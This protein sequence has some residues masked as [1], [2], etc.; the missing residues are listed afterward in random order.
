[1]KQ[2]FLWLIILIVLL[3]VGLLTWFG[4]RFAATEKVV[5][6]QRF[7]Q[8]MQERLSDVN[9]QVAAQFDEAERSLQQVTAFD[10]FRLDEI[11]EVVRTKPQVSQIFVLRSDGEL[12]YPQPGSTL[13]VT[14]RSFLQQASKMFTGKDLQNA[15]VLREAE[16]LRGQQGTSVTPGWNGNTPVYPVPPDPSLQNFYNVAPTTPPTANL[17]PAFPQASPTEPGPFPFPQ[18]AMTPPLQS[19]DPL[20]GQSP[21]TRRMQQPTMPPQSR[22]V[23]LPGRTLGGESGAGGVAEGQQQA[24]GGIPQFPG[25]QEFTAPPA[26]DDNRAPTANAMPGAMPNANAQQ[27]IAW[28]QSSGWFVWYWDRGMNLIYWQRRPSGLIVG[29]AL[30]RSRWISDLIC[31]ARDRPVSQNH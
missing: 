25:F 31:A 7:Q 30:E 5:T 6:Q 27:Q 15:V 19:A 12:L 11:R 3:P 26:Q 17:T 4:V 18:P 8:L 23:P 14:E 2:R 22:G 21:S 1:M 13:N 29:A 16:L 28:P 10:A 24:G 9:R 20:A